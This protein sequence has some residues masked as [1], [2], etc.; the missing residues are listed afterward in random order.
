MQFLKRFLAPPEIKAALGIL[1]EAAYEFNYPEFDL[2]KSTIQ[3]ELLKFQNEVISEINKGIL[4]RAL[5]Y[6]M[7]GLIIFD[8][9]SSGHYHI[10]R[11]VLNPMQG[12]DNLLKTY[13]TAIKEQ[14][15]LKTINQKEAAEWNDKMQNAI[16]TVG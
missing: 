3:R 11:G 12:G 14:L 6:R 4:P 5:V 1:D 15:K 7:I 16:A 10:Y 2:V 9:L 8:L 13:N